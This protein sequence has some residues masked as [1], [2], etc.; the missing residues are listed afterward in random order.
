MLANVGSPLFGVNSWQR[1][2]VE[3]T[4]ATFTIGEATFVLSGA[5]TANR[6]EARKQGQAEALNR[7]FKLAGRRMPSGVA[8]A[9]LLEV[10]CE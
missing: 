1:Q 2:S 4:N 8:A 5:G 9:C 3:P 6:V 10:A 7:R